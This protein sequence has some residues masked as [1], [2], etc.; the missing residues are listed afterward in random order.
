[1]YTSLT[2]VKGS[3]CELGKTA[4]TLQ[5]KPLFVRQILEFTVGLRKFVEK[6]Y[7]VSPIK[8]LLIIILIK[9]V[10]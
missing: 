4:V 6:N 3:V 1:M 2:T 8:K 10:W 7:S 9:D 5:T